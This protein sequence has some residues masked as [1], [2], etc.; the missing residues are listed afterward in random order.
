MIMF[1]FISQKNGEEWRWWNK[2]HKRR[3][4]R[5]EEISLHFRL[6]F[7]DLQLLDLQL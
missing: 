6:F 7:L 4:S 5:R 2:K 1:D 3:K